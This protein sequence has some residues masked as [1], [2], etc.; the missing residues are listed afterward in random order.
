MRRGFESSASGS[1]LER[2][3]PYI[4]DAVPA[5][6]PNKIDINYENKVHLVGYKVE[7]AGKAAPGDEIKVTLY[8]R[9][10]AKLDEGWSLFTH[11]LDSNNERVLNIDNVGPLREIKESH[12]VLW[13]SAWEKG[14]VYVDEQ[15]FRVPDD[16]KTAEIAITAGIWKGDAR[17][18]VVSGPGDAENRGIITRLKTGVDN[19]PAWRLTPSSPAFA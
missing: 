16:V 3:K 2:L 9:A 12:Q 19:K 4:L 10:D 14:K 7:P 18:K 5:D 13:P 11:I 17:L 15:S 6:L 1:D 8:W